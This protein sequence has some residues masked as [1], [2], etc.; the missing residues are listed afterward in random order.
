MK[1]PNVV[2]EIGENAKK[3][4]ERRERERERIVGAKPTA[5]RSLHIGACSL[6]G[7]VSSDS[8]ACKILIE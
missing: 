8:W 2:L 1:I 6:C 4:R 3:R 7:E 5:H